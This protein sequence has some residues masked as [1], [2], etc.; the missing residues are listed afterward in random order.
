MYSFR[1]FSNIHAQLRLVQKANHYQE[2][3]F[4]I[5][6]IIPERASAKG[7]RDLAA[8]NDEGTEMRISCEKK[9]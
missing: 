4:K 1:D 6:R 5:S 7:Q 3:S 9:D 2:K 8:K